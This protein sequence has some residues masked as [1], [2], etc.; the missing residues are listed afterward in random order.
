[1][2]FRLLL[3]LLIDC[4]VLKVFRLKHL[5][6]I[7]IK[8]KKKINQE[9]KE[10]TNTSRRKLARNLSHKRKANSN[11]KSCVRLCLRMWLLRLLARL[12]VR[13][14]FIDSHI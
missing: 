3:S 11:T 13:F 10:P 14:H 12:F 1:M 5:I 7:Q 2:C 8:R 4:S 9:Y 6:E